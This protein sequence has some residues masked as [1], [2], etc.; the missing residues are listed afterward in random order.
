MTSASLGIKVVNTRGFNSTAP[1]RILQTIDGVDNASP[2]VNFALGNFLGSSE[3]DLR[4]VDLIVGASS[5]FYGPN[6]FNGVIKMDSKDPFFSQGLSA[7][8]KAG[9]QN[10]LEAG[11]RWADALK[12]ENGD[13]LLHIACG[14]D[15]FDESIL[16][17]LLKKR[18]VKFLL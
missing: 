9:E 18:F 6:A 5:A 8:V 2:S 14:S 3:L 11:V 10:I 12:N 16:T 17:E 7:F 15:N 13:G 1:V 4:S